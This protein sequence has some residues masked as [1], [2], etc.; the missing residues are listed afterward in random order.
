MKIILSA[1]AELLPCIRKWARQRRAQLNS[2]MTG[3]CEHIPIFSHAIV[4]IRNCAN[5]DSQLWAVSERASEWVCLRLCSCAIVARF[6]LP[7]FIF[8]P[9]FFPFICYNK[10]HH[11]F[12]IAG[13]FFLYFASVCKT[14]LFLKQKLTIHNG[15]MKLTDF[16]LYTLCE[17]KKKKM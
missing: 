4:L 12:L 1:L 11:S 6:C 2:M 10:A 5:C 9:S 14:L 7:W 3:S 17:Q 16:T 13:D 15:Y 8:L